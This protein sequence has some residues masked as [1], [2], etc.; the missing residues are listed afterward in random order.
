MKK[1]LVAILAALPLLASAGAVRRGVVSTSSI[2]AAS[3]ARYVVWTSHRVLTAASG[4]IASYAYPFAGGARL[5]DA[6]FV[7]YTPGA[8]GTSW[9]GDIRKS[10]GTS[11]LTTKCT[12]TLASGSYK[13]TDAK[14]DLALQPGWTR[15]VLKTD[16]TVDV[17]KGDY[18]EL[19][20]T[21]T[22]TYSTHATILV[23]LVFEP[24]A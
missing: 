11:L 19:H 20:T 5:V 13:R 12:G 10:D 23:I 4:S 16:A 22:G 17:A 9:D 24:K 18:L 15:P 6:I 3:P 1:I 21:E 7:Q 8:G 14:G 2:S